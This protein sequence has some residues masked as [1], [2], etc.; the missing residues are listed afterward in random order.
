[1]TLRQAVLEGFD[2]GITAMMRHAPGPIAYGASGLIA[3]HLAPRLYPRGA[4]YARENLAR[5]RPGQPP[6]P[7]LAEMW[8]CVGRTLME[9]PRLGR[10]VREGRI[11]HRGTEH[12]ARRPLLVAGL[13]I[14]NWECI[15]PVM[16]AASAP[17]AFVYQ[18]LRSAFRT[19]QAVEARRPWTTALLPGSPAVTRP[20]LRALGRP[21]GVLLMFMDEF[22]K[23]RVAA[24]S[25]GRGPRRG[26][27][28]ATIARMAR[29][30][31]A[32]VV[33][34]WCRRRPG[35]QFEVTFEP[36]MDLPEVLDDAVAQ[37]DAAAEAIILGN[38]PQWLM[39]HEWRA[40]G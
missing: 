22:F 17:P 21:D 4:R 28:I 27:N 7:A 6:E 8:D 10:M 36:P 32:A 34:A 5:F 25:L 19:R 16:A 33:L 12:L 3:R 20:A 37:L 30:T 23:G 24:P 29:M 15:A 40:E 31:G 35:P 2:R 9:T 26:G 39:L 1:V 13:H 14:G 38:L 18:S 11:T